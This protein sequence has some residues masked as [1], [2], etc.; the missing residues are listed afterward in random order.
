MMVKNDTLS[1]FEGRIFCDVIAN[2]I[3]TYER[4]FSNL[5]LLNKK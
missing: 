3:M 5:H 1:T 2:K 4:Y